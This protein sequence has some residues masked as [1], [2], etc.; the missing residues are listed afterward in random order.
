MNDNLKNNILL[1]ESVTEKRPTILEYFHEYICHH[2][3]PKSFLAP[4]VIWYFLTLRCYFWDYRSYYMFCNC[5]EEMFFYKI[6]FPDND[7]IFSISITNVTMLDSNLIKSYVTPAL[8]E[9]VSMH[10]VRLEFP[11]EGWSYIFV[12]T[13]KRLH[14][15][16]RC[17]VNNIHW[18]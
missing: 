8:P 16:C 10:K 9:I 17:S 5:K 3:Q 12:E 2:Y 14:K 18:I 4:F 15:F 6:L 13:K 1:S 7:L 11:S